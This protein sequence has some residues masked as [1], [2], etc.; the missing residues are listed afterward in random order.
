MEIEARDQDFLASVLYSSADSRLRRPRLGRRLR[1]PFRG[2]V[3]AKLP[4]FV[5]AIGIVV[6]GIVC[7]SDRS[8]TFTEKVSLLWIVV[9]SVRALRNGERPMAE[10][11]HLRDFFPAVVLAAL[12]SMIGALLGA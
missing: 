2:G 4:T 1:V 5:T 8:L 6:I 10:S 11:M 7:V 9:F 3:I 12:L